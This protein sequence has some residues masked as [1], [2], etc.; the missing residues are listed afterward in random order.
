MN[1]YIYILASLHFLGLVFFGKTTK[2]RFEILLRL[3]LLAPVYL[4]ALGH[5]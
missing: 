3:A 5:I 1:T 4:R 2:E